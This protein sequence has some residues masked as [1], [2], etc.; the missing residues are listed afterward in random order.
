LRLKEITE[1]PICLVEFIPDA[2][3]YRLGCS[4]LHMFHQECLDLLIASEKQRFRGKS[5]CPMC[6][7]D[8][9]EARM[10]KVTYKG[11]EEL[12]IELAEI[13]PLGGEDPFGR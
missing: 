7:A 13:D 5:H 6:R 10:T 12:E 9:V 3:I 2:H 11:L 1:C 4:P 8:I